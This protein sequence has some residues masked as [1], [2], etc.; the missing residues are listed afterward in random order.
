MQYLIKVCEGD[1]IVVYLSN[2]LE[3]GG[4]ITLHWHGLHMRGTPFMDGSPM[5]TQCA[6]LPADTFRFI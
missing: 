5:V 6:V 2:H 1:T 3:D 4:A